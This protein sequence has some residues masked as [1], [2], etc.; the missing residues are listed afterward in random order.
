MSLLKILTILFSKAI[1]RSELNVG[2][3][4]ELGLTMNRI[5]MLKY[6]FGRGRGE[7]S[8]LY[9]RVVCSVYA[10]AKRPSGPR[11][12]LRES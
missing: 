5:S 6:C 11:V 10:V 12:G 9:M 3:Y 2:G 8:N 4:G 7:V 1:G